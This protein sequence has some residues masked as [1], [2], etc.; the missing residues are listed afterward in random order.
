MAKVTSPLFSL[1]ASGSIG[2]AMTFFGWK[3]TNVVRKWLKPANPQSANQGNQRT[4]L[5]GTGRGVGEIRPDSSFAQQ[6]I[7]LDLVGPGETKQSM[8]VAY[9]LNHYLTDA[10]A[11]ASELAALTGHAEYDVWGTAATA[12][13]AFT[14]DLLTPST[15]VGESVG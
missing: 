2:K 9:I 12:D 5:G 11:Y 4:F 10:T 13:N 3:G 6:L 1:A 8:M 14:Y 15:R 7:D